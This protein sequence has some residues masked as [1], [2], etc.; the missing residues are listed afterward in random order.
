M[1]KVFALAALAATCIAAVF[2]LAAAASAQNDDT[3][4]RFLEVQSESDDLF[5]D[6]DHNKR[7]SFGDSFAGSL[8]LYDEASV[9]SKKGKLQRGKRIGHAKIMCS[10]GYGENAFCQGTFFLPGGTIQGQSYIKLSN[11]ITVAVVGGTGKYAGARGTFTSKQIRD[12][13]D[14]KGNFTS[15]ASDTITLL[16]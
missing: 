16:P 13:K 12:W 8:V 15:L 9:L 14:A 10:F 1:R 5:Y 4:V 2:I 11:N 7:P 6:A 3:V